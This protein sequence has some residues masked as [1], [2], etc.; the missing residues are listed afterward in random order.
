MRKHH[1]SIE[2]I[3]FPS[4]FLLFFGLQRP[5]DAQIDT[6]P[7]GAIRDKTPRAHALINAR[8]VIKPGTVVENGALV[9]RDGIIVA[10]GS[11][12]QPP[13]DA[14]IWD[15]KGRTVYP[16]FIDVCSHYGVKS[17]DGSAAQRSAASAKKR[18][19]PSH[20]NPFVVPQHTAADG[21]LADDKKAVK[22]RGQG[23]T[24]ALVISEK[25]VFRGNASLIGLG[26]S[27]SHRSILKAEAAQFISL[28]HLN[29][30]SSPSFARAYPSTL[31]GIFA[32]VRQTLLDAQWYQA[33]Q[34]TYS[35]NPRQQRPESNQALQVLAAEMSAKR[36][37]I[38]SVNDELNIFTAADIAGTFKLPFLILGSGSEYRL[39][40]DVRGVATSFIL[41]LNFPEAPEVDTP[42][43]ALAASLE[44]LRHYHFAP[45]NPR[46]LHEAGIKFAFTGAGLKDVSEFLPRLRRAIDRGLPVDAALSALTVNP[47][48]FF[49]VERQLGTLESGKIANLVVSQ[50]ELFAENS[51]IQEV[52]IDGSR[53]AVKAGPE[54]DPRGLWRLQTRTASFADTT[55]LQLKGKPDKLQGTL[56]LGEQKIKLT[57]VKLAFSRLSLMFPGDSLGRRGMV[58]MSGNLSA[59]A[60]D[61]VGEWPDG[62]IFTWKAE[63]EA[64]YQAPPDTLKKEK[65]K[66][67]ALDPVY[68]TG[69][70]GRMKP[71]A[72]PAN[73]LL[74]NATI[75]S[76]AEAGRLA[77]ADMLVAGG[78]IVAVGRNV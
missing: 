66:A 71:P 46:V 34:A 14:R 61:G 9:M 11:N 78:K 38:F 68:P 52:W 5:L 32:L 67:M 10:A 63:R 15:M 41:P 64:S 7:A 27:A 24:S 69:G 43:E 56:I 73:L 62:A 19:G 37:F 22:M 70:Y 30:R 65:E 40:N 35:K 3:I 4:I 16:G 59:D 54:I 33:A 48:G 76:C 72:Q 49:G 25:G 8:L 53:F 26:D 17:S 12:V 13:A 1:Y 18:R 60:V 6:D 57:D 50:G 77:G 21:F 55:R 20:W 39:V 42:E 74:R 28:Q 58:R 36:P 23:F 45:D 31:M 2:R 44:E 47:A 75:W 29:S 51:A